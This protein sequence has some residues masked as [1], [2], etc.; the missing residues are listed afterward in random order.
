MSKWHDWRTWVVNVDFA[1]VVAALNVAVAALNVVG[2]A[3]NV[4]TCRSK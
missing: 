4:V 3:L 2:F 1:V